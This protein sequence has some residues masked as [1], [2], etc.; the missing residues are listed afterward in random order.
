MKMKTEIKESIDK[1]LTPERLKYEAMV[2][3][4]NYFEEDDIEEGEE[5]VDVI[6]KYESEEIPNDIVNDMGK[7]LMDEFE[8]EPYCGNQLSKEENEE[9]TKYI[10]EKIRV[11]Y[12]FFGKF[13]EA[14]MKRNE[15]LE[16]W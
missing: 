3:F 2:N 13:H 10:Q 14:M 8:I 16:N 15:G 5:F 7:I 11:V 12:P 9:I 1:F 4:D 6:I